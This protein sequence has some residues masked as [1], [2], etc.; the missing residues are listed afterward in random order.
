V[1]IVAGR[2][3]RVVV[4]FPWGTRVEFH[5]DR[6]YRDEAGT[7]RWLDGG[8]IGLEPCLDSVIQEKENWILGWCGGTSDVTAVISHGPEAPEP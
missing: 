5:T 7:I 2:R 6:V 4:R 8:E 3:Y 1:E